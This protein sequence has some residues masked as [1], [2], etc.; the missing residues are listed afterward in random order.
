MGEKSAANLLAAIDRSSQTTLPRLLY[1]LGI[2]E[3]G[4]ATAL[5][6]ARHF[7][8]LERLMSADEAAIQQVPDIGP[9]VA[10]HVAAFFTSA[11]HRSVI[12]ALRDKGVTWPEMESAAAATSLPLAGRTFVLTGTL[13]RL[14]REEAQEA[15]TARGAKVAGNVSKRTS[16][17]VAGSEA[18][19]KL[20]RARELGIT[21]LDETQLLELL[22]RGG[23]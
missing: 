8:T 1:G 14:T 23:S 20:D 19:S 5:A 17:V 22:G 11:E 9:V 16:F 21:V 13:E 7:G 12:K 10:A 15:L 6:L 3:V 4:E 18:G 2:R